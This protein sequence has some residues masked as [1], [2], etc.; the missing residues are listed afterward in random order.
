MHVHIYVYKRS[1]YATNN[2]G[3]ERIIKET[4]NRCDAAVGI[5]PVSERRKTKSLA[6][7]NLLDSKIYAEQHH[8]SSI[9]LYYIMFP[10]DIYKGKF[11]V[12]LVPMKKQIGLFRLQATLCEFM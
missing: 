7:H 9:S 3:L 6:D 12:Y 2:L 5:A 8:I 1:L 10:Y 4:G 11:L